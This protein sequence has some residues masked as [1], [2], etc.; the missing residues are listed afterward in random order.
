MDQPSAAAFE[1]VLQGLGFARVGVH[2]SKAVTRWR[3]GDIN[4]VV[5]R[6]M[7]GF[8][9]SFN[10]THGPSVCAIALRVD[11]ASATIERAVKLLDRPFRQAVGPGELDIP[12]VRGVGGSPGTCWG[13]SLSG[14]SALK[15]AAVRSARSTER[16]G[17]RQPSRRQVRRRARLAIDREAAGRAVG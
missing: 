7:E 1:N 15:R 9:H 3:Q 5:N 12:A 10:I 14:S 13:P 11:D 16:W 4:I 8:A 2:R 6:E 17:G